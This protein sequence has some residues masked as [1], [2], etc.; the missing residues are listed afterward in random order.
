MV[1]L[2]WMKNSS[3]SCDFKEQKWRRKAAY[4]GACPGKQHKISWKSVHR[5]NQIKPTAYTVPLLWVCCGALSWWKHNRKKSNA[6]TSADWLLLEAADT[7]GNLLKL[8]R[9]FSFKESKVWLKSALLKP[10]KY[11]AA[12]RGPRSV[13]DRTNR[14]GCR[15]ARADR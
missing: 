4:A 1:C 3:I 2:S 9:H 15:R 8:W 6:C 14:A 10:V 12:A 11:W 5:L 13:W 7:W